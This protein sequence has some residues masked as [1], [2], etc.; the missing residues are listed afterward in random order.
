MPEAP[1][2]VNLATVSPDVAAL[3]L[4]PRVVAERFRLVPLERRADSLTVAMVDTGDVITID[5]I[6]RLAGGRVIPVAASPTDIQAA[7]SR[8]YTAAGASYE[9]PV[10]EGPVS[11]TSTRRV[12]E[13][14]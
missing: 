2:F 8:L 13:S 7:I 11:G 3:H 1:A 6:A 9:T 10:S 4:V 14:M 5:E 12:P